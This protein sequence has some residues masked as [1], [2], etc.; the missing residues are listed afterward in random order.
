MN[1]RLL[2]AV[3]LTATAAWGAATFDSFGGWE[4]L[5]WGMT[6]A[7][8][9]AALAAAGARPELHDFPKDGTSILRFEREGWEKATAYF[10]DR[11]FLCQVLLQS[12]P[13]NTGAEARGREAVVEA[14]Y[15]APTSTRAA[16]Y[17]PDREDAFYVWENDRTVL[18]VTLAHYIQD[19]NWIVWEEYLPVTTPPSLEIPPNAPG[20][21]LLNP[22]VERP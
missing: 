3:Y 13:V 8:A 9:H 11:G 2:V 1:V 4:N 22:P 16:R 20:P 6:V 14:L 17:G 7:A 10:N 21:E 5:P 12:P 15:G 19:G 18:T